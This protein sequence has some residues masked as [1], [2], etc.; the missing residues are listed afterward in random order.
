MH[1]LQIKQKSEV[2]AGTGVQQTDMSDMSKIE[3]I[4][5]MIITPP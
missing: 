3:N 4:G 2:A 1:L 5:F